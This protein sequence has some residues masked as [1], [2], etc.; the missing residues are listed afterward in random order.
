MSRRRR[1]HGIFITGTDTGV[2]KT[3]V[4]CALASWYRARG[5]DVGVMKPVATGGRYLRGPGGGRWVSEDA[6]CLAACAEVTDPWPLINPVCFREPL[7]PWTAARRTHSAVRLDAVLAAFHALAARHDILIVEGIGGLLVP[8]S[9]H[10]TVA[11]LAT[12]LGLPVVLVARPDLGTLNH[13]LLSLAC[14][15]RLSLRYRGLILNHARPNPR[16]RWDRLAQRTNPPMLRQFTRLVGTVPFQ[17]LLSSQGRGMDGLP[18]DWVG[19][20]LDHR[21]L[22]RMIG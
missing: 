9:R 17:P 13:T 10:Q 14:I 22:M 11:H 21:I 3:V 7:A 16:G 5:L 12:R 8:L 15:R 6:V 18:A 4:A 19:R 2:G 1:P 20:H